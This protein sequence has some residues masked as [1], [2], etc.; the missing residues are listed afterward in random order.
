MERA[1]QGESDRNAIARGGVRERRDREEQPP[2]PQHTQT[3]EMRI[4]FFLMI[5]GGEGNDKVRAGRWEGGGELR[6]MDAEPTI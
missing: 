3:M 6:P 2:S 4:S 5:A 1:G